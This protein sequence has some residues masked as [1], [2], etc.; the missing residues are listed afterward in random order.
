MEIIAALL[1]FVFIASHG[2][3][4][5]C[6]YSDESKQHQW[7]REECLLG[8][9]GDNEIIFHPAIYYPDELRPFEEGFLVGVEKAPVQ[10]ISD[11]SDYGAGLADMQDGYKDIVD[12]LKN[13]PK[14]L[15]I[16]HIIEYP[17]PPAPDASG[18]TPS[19]PAHSHP[20]YNL[21]TDLRTK[22]NATSALKGSW[23]AIR[24]LQDAVS[25]RIASAAEG[26]RPYTHLILVS[27][28]W[29]TPQEEAVRNFRSISLRLGETEVATNNPA[30]RPLYI[31]V[32]WPSDWG[33][34]KAETL[35]SYT[36]KAPDADEL[37]LSWLSAIVKNVVAPYTDTGKLG[38]VV[39][40]HSFGARTTSMAVCSGGVFSKEGNAKDGKVNLL[41]SLEGAYSINRFIGGGDYERIAYPGIRACERAGHI[42]LTASK[43]DSAVS[44]AF[45]APMTGEIKSYEKF[46]KDENTFDCQKVS[47]DGKLN[48]ATGYA[49]NRHIHYLDATELL[50]YNAY[51]SGGGAHSD[52]YR[53]ETAVMLRQAI[54]QFAPSNGQSAAGACAVTVEPRSK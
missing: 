2:Q 22:Q 1:A 8:T 45:W 14:R 53:S 36:N 19:R 24:F 12:R 18:K 32:T 25:K 41:V 16:S 42:V 6:P 10:K 49:T 39:I 4:A 28:G 13:N 23:D 34:G 3:A 50:K 52:I 37:G 31:G 38:T 54:C 21:Y 47:A 35:V 44:I 30:F 46:C 29:N 26:R 27:M 40:G 51:G 33:G 15:F 48:Q 7:A 9:D 5:S 43:N 17:E 20:L 11:E